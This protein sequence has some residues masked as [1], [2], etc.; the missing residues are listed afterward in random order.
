M[1]KTIDLHRKE[2]VRNALELWEEKGELREI[3]KDPIIKLFFAALAYQSHGVLQEMSSFKEEI[4][5]EFRNKLI[6][7]YLI[8][9]FPA[10]TIIQ[11]KIKENAKE[12]VP[13]LSSFWI[14]EKSIFEFGKGKCPFT[15]LFKTKI[16]RATVSNKQVNQKT[17]TIDITLSSNEV[18]DDYSGLSFFIEGISDYSDVEIS[19]DNKPLPVIKPADY[20]SLP[21]TE[22]FDS[23]FLL[24]EDNQLQLGRFDYWQELY[25]KNQFQLFYIGEY[26]PDKII[27]RNPS[28]VF[29]IRFKNQSPLEYL[30]DC[31]I[32]INCFPVVNV[33]FN[34]TYLTDDEPIK[35]LSTDKSTFLSLMVDKNVSYD[36]DRFIIRHYGVERYNHK[37]LLFQLN[38]LFNR[39]IS[40]YYAFKD[41]E[42]LKKGEKLE[43]I[44]KTFKEIL[45]VIKKDRDD[46]HPSVY[47]ILKLRDKL[48][49]PSESVKIN[50]L[51]TNCELANG[52]K[53]G[54]KPVTI[55]EYLD[56][57]QTFLLKETEG[58]RN[59]ERNEERLNHLA[60]Y[61][62]LTKDKIVTV[63]DMKAFCYMELQNKIRDVSVK[64]TGEQIAIRIKLKDDMMP[65]P[66]ERAYYES[67]LREKIYARSLLCLPVKVTIL[68]L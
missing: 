56:K 18:I 33:Q 59:E 9:P 3:E 5:N 13:A 36:S 28:P 57:E 41:I 12:N 31:S 60:R 50:Y 2:I 30:Q 34:T 42:E 26:N 62:L 4:I 21:F 29:T 39:F 64:N 11:T 55:S 7:Y 17:N 1:E 65:E 19:M 52:L 51:T 16:I 22:L 24:S 35:K 40:D 37:E 45:P 20:D 8:K 47:A 58:G 54:E 48:L 23:H 49:R 46:I 66:A 61:N 25:L 44:Y 43:T 53:K 6:P 63:S 15:P 68:P 14:D 10:Y 32:K 38:D 27:N 67:L